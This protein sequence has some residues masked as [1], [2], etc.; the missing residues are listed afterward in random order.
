MIQR[1]VDYIESHL[2]EEFT[3]DSVARKAGLSRWHFPRSSSVR[4]S[5]R[6]YAQGIHPANAGSPPPP[7]PSA[8]PMIGSSTSPSRPGLNHQ[9]TLSP[10]RSKPCSASRI[11]PPAGKAGAKSILIRQNPQADQSL[12]QPPLSGNHHET[13]HQ[14]NRPH[15]HRRIRQKSGSSPPSRRTPSNA[16]RHPQT[17]GRLCETSRGTV[18]NRLSP[19]DYGVV[20]CLGEKDR[21]S[22]PDEMLLHRRHCC[23]R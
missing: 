1:A 4:A 20:I 13:N 14:R 6:S 11:P 12:S 15:A 10:V 3:V 18:E 7:L 8:G 9:R 23:L 16:H 5:V 21:K 17:L 2:H 22:H 19:T